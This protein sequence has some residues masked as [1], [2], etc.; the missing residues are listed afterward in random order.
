MSPWI[1]IITSFQLRVFIV[2][3]F[4]SFPTHHTLY[5]C[6][7]GITQK[8]IAPIISPRLRNEVTI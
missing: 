7:G 3:K 5:V 4:M 2:A 6:F 8:L 1:H